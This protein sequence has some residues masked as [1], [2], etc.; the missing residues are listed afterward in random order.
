MSQFLFGLPSEAEA[1]SPTEASVRL[2]LRRLV[3]QPRADEEEDDTFDEVVRTVVA[4]V[5]AN[6]DVDVV[7]VKL[8]KVTLIYETET[9][10]FKALV[11]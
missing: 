7:E 1:W 9:H 4:T 6:P 3:G 2:A 8:K 11:G 10:K 5:T